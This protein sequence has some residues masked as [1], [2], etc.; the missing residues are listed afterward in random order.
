MYDSKYKLRTLAYRNK[1]HMLA[2]TS[3]VKLKDYAAEHYDAYLCGIAAQF[4]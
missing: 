2:Q 3:A 4:V 1:G